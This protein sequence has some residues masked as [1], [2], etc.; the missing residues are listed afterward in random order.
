MTN[1]NEYLSSDRRNFK[2]KGLNEAELP[3]QPAEL[4][5]Q[6]L[7]DAIAKENPDSYAFA[8]LTSGEGE[9]PDGRMVYLRALEEDGSL[10]FFTNYTSA[11][12]RQIDRDGKVG[13]LF[14]WPLNER[15]VRISG[16]VQKADP[17]VSDA[18]F[19]SRPRSS[20]IGAWASNQSSRLKSRD[21]LEKLV[22]KTKLKF[23]DNEEIPRPNFWGGYIISP[24]QYEFWEGRESRL[25]DRIVYSR[26]NGQW[27]KRRLAP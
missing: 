8:L 13:A 12:A 17:E 23:A 6:W 2:Q 24:V 18:Y 14:F 10:V 26:Q 1:I 4:F 22:E 9:F 21:E 16:A 5:D 11:K 3:E 19:A 25:H 27:K 7:R 15:Q 20:Q